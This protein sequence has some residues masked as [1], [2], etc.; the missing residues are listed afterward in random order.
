MKLTAKQVLLAEL[1]CWVLI[2]LP[3]FVDSLNSI[4]PRILGMPF[5]VVYDLLIILMHTALL[6]VAKKYAWDTF[7]ADINWNAEKEKEGE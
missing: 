6:L 3:F 1:L 2:C 4:E 5:I 7:D